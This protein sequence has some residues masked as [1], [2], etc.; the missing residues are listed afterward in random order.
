MRDI[1]YNKLT[2]FQ[3]IKSL[4]IPD[5]NT[6]SCKLFHTWNLL[7][8][9]FTNVPYPQVFLR[10]MNFVAKFLP[11]EKN[12]LYTGQPIAQYVFFKILMGERGCLVLIPRIFLRVYTDKRTSFS[13][14]LIIKSLSSSSCS[15]SPVK[16]NALLVS[17]FASLSN[18]TRK[19]PLILTSS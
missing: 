8:F 3:I 11:Y 6:S 4:L 15:S 14:S 1:K 5:G 16:Q 2:P 9:P 12:N 19:I 18:L 17:Q 13:I 10:R 7:R